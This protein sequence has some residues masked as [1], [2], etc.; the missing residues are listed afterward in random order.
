MNTAQSRVQIVGT[1]GPSCAAPAVIEQMVRAGLDVVRLNFSWG[2]YDEHR[3]Y[4]RSVRALE[5]DCH[6]TMP[7]IIDLP[8]L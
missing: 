5:A 2:T 1:I 4:I 8:G 6:K 3:G 7:I